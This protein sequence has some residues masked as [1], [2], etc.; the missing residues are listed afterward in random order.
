MESIVS[1]WN[2][3]VS[4]STTFLGIFSTLTLL[5]MQGILNEALKHKLVF[6]ETPDAAETSVALENYRRVCRISSGC[7]KDIV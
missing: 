5:S 3:M 1:A 6:I 7:Q 2:E 4:G